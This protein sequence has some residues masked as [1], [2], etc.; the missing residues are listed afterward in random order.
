MRIH[1]IEAVSNRGSFSICAQTNNHVDFPP[2]KCFVKNGN[3]MVNT[4]HCYNIQFV[5]IQ[6]L[7]AYYA[8]HTGIFLNNH[9]TTGT[10]FSVDTKIINR[11]NFSV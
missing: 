11:K 7:R 4:K 6:Y 5:T 1:H 2:A 8:R 9:K 3:C 10:D